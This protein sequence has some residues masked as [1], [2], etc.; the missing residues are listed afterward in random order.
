MQKTLHDFYHRFDKLF[1]K[2]LEQPL[3]KNSDILLETLDCA[4]ED[5]LETKFSHVEKHLASIQKLQCSYFFMLGLQVKLE[6]NASSIR[7]QVKCFMVI[8]KEA[9]EYV[10][11]QN[12]PVE[13]WPKYLVQ[14]SKKK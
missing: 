13:E 2:S 12:I 8:F 3:T 1:K 10:L 7:L 4:I 14:L 6:E 5:S 9:Y 11:C